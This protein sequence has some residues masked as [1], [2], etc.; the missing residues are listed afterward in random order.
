MTQSLR[1]KVRGVTSG[2]QSRI[3]TY[4]T[5]VTYNTASHREEVNWI[6]RTTRKQSFSPRFPTDQKQCSELPMALSNTESNQAAKIERHAEDEESRI[7]QCC[8]EL[9]QHDQESVLANHEVSKSVETK[10]SVTEKS[11]IYAKANF[12]IRRSREYIP[13]RVLRQYIYFKY[14]KEVFYISLGSEYSFLL[15]ATTFLAFLEDFVLG[16]AILQFVFGI[17]VLLMCVPVFIILFQHLHVIFWTLPWVLCQPFEKEQED[18]VNE[19][20]LNVG[21]LPK[22]YLEA[23]KR[24]IGKMDKTSGSSYEERSSLR[25]KFLSLNGSAAAS[26]IASG[27]ISTFL[28]TLNS[29]A[30][31]WSVLLVIF[32]VIQISHH[33]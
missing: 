18:L 26:V 13:S 6:E 2:V 15:V 32:T 21:K 1:N 33:S 22:K 7:E 4:R 24:G 3:A 30:F 17:L 27:L 12:L 20:N 25:V 11:N 29:V 28:L 14:F 9:Q 10:E 23:K 19:I 8:V 31:I 5:R 16:L